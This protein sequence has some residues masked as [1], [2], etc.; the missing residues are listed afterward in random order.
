[1]FTHSSFSSSQDKTDS[2][3]EGPIPFIS[4]VS[5]SLRFLKAGILLTISLAARLPTPEIP[6]E[7]RTIS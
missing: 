3:V 5:M 1:M 7:A 6:R 2:T 4:V